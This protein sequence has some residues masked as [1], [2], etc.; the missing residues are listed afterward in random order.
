MILFAKILG[1]TGVPS[2]PPPSRLL[3]M[4]EMTQGPWMFAGVFTLVFFLSASFLYLIDFVPEARE[5][6]SVQNA[7]LSEEA[8]GSFEVPVRITIPDIGV[9][10]VINN[11]QSVALETLDTALLSGAVR[12]PGSGLLGQ[13][14]ALFLFGH[15]SYLPVVR[16]QA[17]KAFNGLQELDV[18]DTISVHSATAEYRYRVTSVTKVRAEEALIDLESGNQKLILSTCNSF[19]DP[20]ERWVVEAEF[21]EKI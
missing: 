1:G 7:P 11:P 3:R 4:K 8:Q 19:G 9:D 18:N 2:L 17:F 10:T 5:E 13:E 20:G 15:Q 21:V 16:N 12:Y 14:A 6:N